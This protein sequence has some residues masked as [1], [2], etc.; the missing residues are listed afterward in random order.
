MAPHQVTIGIA[1][2]CVINARVFVGKGVNAKHIPD[3]VRLFEPEFKKGLDSDMQSSTNRKIE[4]D[5][6]RTCYKVHTNEYKG[7]ALVDWTPFL[8]GMPL[9]N[10]VLLEIEMHF[11][12][13]KEGEDDDE[14]QFIDEKKVMWPTY[15]ERRV[16]AS[17]DIFVQL[18][19]R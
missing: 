1:H 15:K 17:C 18:A 4:G 8:Q 14:S 19:S 10:Q 11:E 5:D 16:V 2:G 3:I 7:E 9:R 13:P 6:Q 12:E